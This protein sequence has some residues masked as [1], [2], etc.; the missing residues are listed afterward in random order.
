MLI[1]LSWLN[2]PR[3]CITFDGLMTRIII[4]VAILDRDINVQSKT[5]PNIDPINWLIKKP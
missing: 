4:T 3:M 1:C 5:E 2:K